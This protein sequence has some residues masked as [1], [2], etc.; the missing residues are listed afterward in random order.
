MAWTAP[1]TWVTAEIVTAALMNTHLRDNLNAIGEHRYVRKP[2]NEPVVNSVI[3][4]DDDD[5][6][7]AIGAN[8]QWIFDC[9]AIVSGSSAA[10]IQVGWNA[11]TG[12]LER[13]SIHPAWD[14]GDAFTI[15]AVI[16]ATGDAR[17][18][19]IVAG[20]RAVLLKGLV[21]NGG[22]AG[23]TGLQWAQ[24]TSNATA[25][26]VQAESHLIAHRKA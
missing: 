12:A 9:V 18:L 5:L 14:A 8:E 15:P 7:F 3:F 1:R 13:V 24:A 6:K 26:V 19:G 11:P 4:Q 25:T 2:A 10:D 20:M 17:T 21:V 22:T 23:N 16:E